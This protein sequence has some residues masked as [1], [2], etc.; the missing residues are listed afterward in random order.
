MNRWLLWLVVAMVCINI[1]TTW[2]TAEIFGWLSA[3]PAWLFILMRDYDVR[4]N[5]RQP[6]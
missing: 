5:I 4:S 1:A 3:L 6:S 2:G